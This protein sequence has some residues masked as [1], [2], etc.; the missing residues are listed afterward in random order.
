MRRAVLP[1]L[2][3][4]LLSALILVSRTV[5]QAVGDFLAVSD[6]LTQSDAV[7]AISGDGE[8]RVRT[9]VDLLTRGYG[10]WLILS[11]GPVG[12]PG[13]AAE[14]AAY[15]RKYHAPDGALLL[16]DRAVSTFGNAV[17]SAGVMR[18]HGLH[19]AILV[20]SPYHMR[21]AVIEFR[22]IFGPQGLTVRALPAQDSFFHLD[23]WWTRRRDRE[24]V[25]REYLKLL[26]F[27][28][29]IH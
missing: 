20:T 4:V 18:G 2:I 10:R 22:S 6:P 19:S 29:G 23:G 27:L 1:L 26:A 21:R 12:E 5:L 11:G 15:A 17:G 8:E 9:A 14:L 16:D 3:L 28:A 7:I 24:L 25:V 13:S